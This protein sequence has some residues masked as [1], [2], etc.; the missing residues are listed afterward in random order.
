MLV[1]RHDDEGA[2]HEGQV[3]TSVVPSTPYYMIRRLPM[4]KYVE[5]GTATKRRNLAEL[6]KHWLT[7][8]IAAVQLKL[9]TTLNLRRK[10]ASMLIGANLEHG[11]KLLRVTT[12]SFAR[13]TFSHFEPRFP[14]VS[15]AT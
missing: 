1:R 15:L 13:Q 11:F 3:S 4:D 5:K 8:L 7:P 10:Q 9:R 12:Q 14:L 6:S 2:S